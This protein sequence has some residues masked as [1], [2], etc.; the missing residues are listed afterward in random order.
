MAG[1]SD[2]AKRSHDVF[3]TRIDEAAFSRALLEAFPDLDFWDKGH[4][5]REV[6][7]KRIPALELGETLQVDAC[8]PRP[9]WTPQLG[10]MDGRV[11]G[12]MRQWRRY[13]STA[14]S[15]TGRRVTANGPAIRRS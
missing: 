8:V 7:S 1:R 14:P 10:A 2:F 3:M 13:G 4:L 12:G 15:G 11:T 5:D 6:I 9:G